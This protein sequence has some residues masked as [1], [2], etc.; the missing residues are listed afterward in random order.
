M[1]GIFLNN[2]Q[3]EK[4]SMLEF[5]LTESDFEKKQLINKE[6]CRHRVAAI[7]AD[8]LSCGID[9]TIS[10]NLSYH[11]TSDYFYN[12][13][14]WYYNRLVLY[15]YHNYLLNQSSIFHLVVYLIEN[16]NEVNLDNAVYDLNVSTSYIYKLISQF[17]EISEEKLD[18]SIA[19]R[20]K[21]ISFAGPTNKLISLV[22]EFV[23][24]YPLN[25]EIKMAYF[26]NSSPNDIELE[27]VRPY[28]LR[29]FNME[30][31][32]SNTALLFN[33]YSSMHEE[34]ESI[35]DNLEVGYDLMKMGGPIVELLYILIDYYSNDYEQIKSKELLLYLVDWVKLVTLVKVTPVDLF[36]SSIDK[37]T[38]ER[39]SGNVT[40]E[41]ENLL[42]HL[43][44]DDIEFTKEQFDALL[45]FSR[46]FLEKSKP[47]KKIKI[48]VRIV[49]S[50]VLTELYRDSIKE[51][52]NPE[53]IELVSN[54]DEASIIVTDNTKSITL[55]KNGKIVYLIRD[56]ITEFETKK[57]RQFIV[58]FIDTV[59]QEVAGVNQDCVEKLSVHA[60]EFSV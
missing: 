29:I 34:K 42:K 43:S 38:L 48:Y 30:E 7:N 16:N 41:S 27:D 13:L 31:T 17:N 40:Q 23:K 54:S 10:N 56:V 8:L 36:F 51:I 39:Y 45:L 57:Y 15:S 5:I 46:P 28:L 59:D 52:F 22:F 18:I 26:N 2:S 49:D 55:R 1:S 44:L 21:T 11:Y 4:Y 9:M 25:S 19:I 3:R 24:A 50:L 37:K 32:S 20:K 58:N 12:K 33:M 53:T 14:T 47:T 6:T 60:K 35:S